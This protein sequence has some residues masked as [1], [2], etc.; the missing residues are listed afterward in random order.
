MPTGPIVADNYIDD[1]NRTTEEVQD[2]LNQIFDYVR[3]VKSELDAL[4]SP[5]LREA[6]VRSIGTLAD[7]VPDTGVLNTRLGTTGN[8]GTAAQRN[9][10]AGDNDLVEASRSITAGSGL[11]GGGTFAANRTISHADTSSAGSSNNSGGV[12]IQDI[13]LDQFGHITAIATAG[14][15]VGGVGSYACLGRFLSVGE[16]YA[17]PGT[18]KAGSELTY[19]NNLELQNS[20]GGT[21][22]GTWI[23]MGYMK[24][25]GTSFSTNVSTTW[26]R[27]S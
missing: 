7:N 15:S 6:A 27:I 12:F 19:A 14:G 5:N 2:A 3:A 9:V 20:W 23:C 8:L 21:P 17:T 26:L 4:S 1:P 16:T 22:S 11:T 13:T 24:N 25:G 18:V 10:G